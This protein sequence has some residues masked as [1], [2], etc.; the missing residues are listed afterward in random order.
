MADIVAHN[1]AHIK[2]GKNHT[3]G[4][5][6]YVEVVAGLRVD[7]R[8]QRSRNGMYQEFEYQCRN[9]TEEAYEKCEYQYEIFS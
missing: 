1:I 6:Q 4:R 7:M 8:G 2:G 5:Q 9:A 3:Y